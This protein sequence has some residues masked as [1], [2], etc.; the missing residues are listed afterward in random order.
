[1]VKSVTFGHFSQN[2]GLDPQKYLL[3]PK[4]AVLG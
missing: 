4:K 1:M 3:D 2:R